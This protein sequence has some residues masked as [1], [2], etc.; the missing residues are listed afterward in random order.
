MT[1]R[2]FES[3]LDGHPLPSL[4]F[5]DVPTGS[6]GIVKI[7]KVKFLNELGSKQYLWYGVRLKVY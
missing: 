2:L 7:N 3:K 4:E 5:V 1:L 6:L